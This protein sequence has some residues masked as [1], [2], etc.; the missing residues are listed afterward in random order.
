MDFNIQKRLKIFEICLQ[1]IQKQIIKKILVWN[2]RTTWNNKLT[3][4]KEINSK[5][6]WILAIKRDVQ[7]HHLYK[8]EFNLSKQS[9]LIVLDFDK[10]KDPKN[11]NEI[12]D[13]R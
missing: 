4:W 11:L 9:Q 5:K 1:K 7:E 13:N 12:I 8:R 3:K 2:L 10:D 6:I